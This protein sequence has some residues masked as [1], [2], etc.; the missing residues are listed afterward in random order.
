MLELTNLKLSNTG[1]EK[2]EELSFEA[3][4]DIKGGATGVP[5]AAWVGGTIFGAAGVF[6]GSA[7]S[8]RYGANPDLQRSASFTGGSIGVLA[9]TAIGASLSE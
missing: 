5:G 2:S 7:L 8:R 3:Q 4:Q 1:F 9:G 6:V